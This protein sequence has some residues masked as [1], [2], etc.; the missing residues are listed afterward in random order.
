VRAWIRLQPA[1]NSAGWALISAWSGSGILLAMSQPGLEGSA[2]LTNVTIAA[3]ILD[4]IM[5]LPGVTATLT[6]GQF[7]TWYVSVLIHVNL[8]RLMR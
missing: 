8:R 7:P 6:Q 2:P 4:R 1:L 3:K 5:A